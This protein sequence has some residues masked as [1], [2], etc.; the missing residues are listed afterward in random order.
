MGRIVA[1]MLIGVSAGICQTPVKEPDTLQV[2][3]AEVHLLRQDLEAVTIASQR[4]Q[5][6]LYSL[7]M[8]DGAVA[9]AAQRTEEAHKKCAGESEGRDRALMEIQNSE[10]ALAKGDVPP[11]QVKLIRQQIEL[12]K[13]GIRLQDSAVQRCQLTMADADSKLSAEQAKL[14]ELQ[15]RI[16]QLDK[17][18]EKPGVERK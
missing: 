5:I 15:D 6:A 1:M 7:Q 16:S 4:V 12:D 3:L 2:L 8:Q 17:T 18:L 13:A 14:A 11:E 9:R 10:N